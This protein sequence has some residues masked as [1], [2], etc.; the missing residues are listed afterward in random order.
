MPQKQKNP[1]GS[2]DFSGILKRERVLHGWSQGDVA[3]RIG[4]DP[5]TV[6]RWERGI[7]FPGPHLCQQ[8]SQLY[9]KSVQELGLVRMEPLEAEGQRGES[10]EKRT[11]LLPLTIGQWLFLLCGLCTTLIVLIVIDMGWYMQEGL[12]PSPVTLTGDPYTHTGALALNDPLAV[13]SAAGWSL[14]NTDEGQCFFANGVY[15]VRGIKNQYMKLCLA[16]ETYFTNFTYEVKMQIVAGDCGGLAFRVTF[17]QL[18]Y[19]TLCQDGRY[20]FVRY[21]RDNAANRRIFASDTSSAI[22]RGLNNINLMAVVANGDAFAFYI[23]HTLVYRGSDGAY[24]DGQIGL[25]VH[26]CSSVYLDSRPDVCAAPVEAVFSAAK[27]WKR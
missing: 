12:P 23:N 4:S 20:R 24:L 3:A 17:P 6:G 7:T 15:R 11:A 22:H 26:T 16:A 1:P 14:S 18:Y 10:R 27:V 21:D 9:E 13:E 2:P 8:L 19:F 25:L 5:K